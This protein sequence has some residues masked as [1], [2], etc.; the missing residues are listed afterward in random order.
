MLKKCTHC[1]LIISR[2]PN[3]HRDLLQQMLKCS[4]ISPY[5]LSIIIIIIIIFLVY[6]AKK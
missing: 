5:S 6:E 1:A 3:K 4:I 2:N